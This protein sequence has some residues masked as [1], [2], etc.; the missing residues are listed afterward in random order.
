MIKKV[1]AITILISL[2]LYFAIIP[3]KNHR[4]EL[5]GKCGRGVIKKKIVFGLLKR[6][7]KVYT[8]IVGDCRED[9]LL[10]MIGKKVSKISVIDSDGWKG[11]DGLIDFGYKKHY[12]INNIL[13]SYEE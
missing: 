9:T 2:T 6:N 7:G 11:Y 8:E 12:R 1:R 13:M 10:S 4:Q 3:N 5:G